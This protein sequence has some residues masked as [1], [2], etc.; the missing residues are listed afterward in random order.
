MRY[1]FTAILL[2]GTASLLGCA[3]RHSGHSVGTNLAEGDLDADT[4]MLL[5]P[6]IERESKLLHSYLKGNLE[7]EQEQF[8]EAT[9]SFAEANKLS[10][11]PEPALSEQLVLLYLNAEERDAALNESEVAFKANPSARN[12]YIYAGMLEA[13]EKFK[14]AIPIHQQIIKQ[15]PDAINNFILL[16]STYVK[17]GRHAEAIQLLSDL[18]KKKP[19]ELSVQYYL[20]RTYELSGDLQS[21]ESHMAKGYAIRPETDRLA[22]DYTRILLKRGKAAKAKEVCKGILQRNPNNALARA[23]NDSLQSGRKIEELLNIL[24]FLEN[25][26]TDPSEVRFKIAIAGIDSNDFEQSALNL[27]FVIAREPTNSKA[28]YYLAS[29]FA[30]RGQKRSAVDQLLKVKR[31]EEMYVESRTL[32][33]FVL[34][35]LGDLNG[36]EKS[37]RAALKERPDDQ[38]LVIHLIDLL[39]DGE[40]YGEA[41]KVVDQGL[42]LG[43]DNDRLLFT[44]GIILHDLGKEA[45]SEAVMEQVIKLNPNHG[46]ALNYIAYALAERGEDLVRAVELITR[47]LDFYPED[48][49]FLDTQGWIYFKQGDFLKARESLE[50]SVALLGEDVAV[51]EH[52]ADCLYRV[53]EAARALE[54]YQIALT[55]A[56][57]SK[58]KEDLSAIP[59]LQRKIQEILQKNPD[60]KRL[61]KL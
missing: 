20:A 17:V 35:Q 9:A 4:V 15:D 38:T 39:R 50:R 60:L 33:S 57:E 26:E 56:R 46:Q 1:I 61:V 23:L 40:K 58:D 13:N 24:K 8:E 54:S 30:S 42:A 48:G 44:K 14:E 52:Y 2:I 36:A 31:G 49:Y 25:F 55:H 21:A 16:A 59:R 22:F 7:L 41:L 53:G 28:R 51:R 47:A 43:G 6:D 10:K 3:S 37:L 18:G 34:K 32:A 27:L 12:A 29:I 19:S 5:D 45:E 11:N